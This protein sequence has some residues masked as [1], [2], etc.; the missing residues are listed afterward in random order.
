MSEKL[1]VVYKITCDATGYAYIGQ[2]QALNAKSIARPQRIPRVRQHRTLLQAGN[3]INCLMQKDFN[4]YKEQSFFIEILEVTSLTNL[5]IAERTWILNTGYLYNQSPRPRIEAVS[6]KNY[7]SPTS[8]N[9]FEGYC[10]Y[11]KTSTS[12]AGNGQGHKNKW[13]AGE[14]KV[15][16]VPKVFADKLLALA[17]EWDADFSETDDN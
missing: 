16:R 17:R 9:L 6:V 2:T 7:P 4:L 15:I 13:L 11:R 12:G 14:T 8:V 3:H 1:G 5:R 10:P